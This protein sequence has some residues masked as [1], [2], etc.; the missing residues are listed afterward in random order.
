MILQ[1]FNL[2]RTYPG[3]GG[4][5]GVNLEISPG[6][7]LLLSGST[8]A[9]KSTLIKLISLRERPDKGYILLDGVSS[10]RLYLSDYHIWRR[11]MGVIPQEL[12]LLPDRSVF[13]NIQL[14]MRGIGLP[15][16]SS[17]RAA[18]KALAKV[19]LSPRLREKVRNLSGGEARRTAIARALCNEPFILLADE[20]LGDLD[21]QTG[22]EIMTLFER[23]NS[24]GTAVLMVT[25]RLDI[26]PK[27][28]HR[29]I[30]M[31]RG[32]LV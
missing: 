10:E 30:K 23:I 26:R 14:I 31:E 8:G 19:G 27:V 16:R 15:A 24:V 11:K 6:E 4:I 7:F 12:M 3:G 1:T 22:A 5:T 2:T 20:P 17:K 18:L 29:E 21:P 25:H 28:K 9:G 13:Q 32:R